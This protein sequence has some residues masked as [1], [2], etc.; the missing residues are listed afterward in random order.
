MRL[1]SGRNVDVVYSFKCKPVISI[2]ISKWFSDKFACSDHDEI[3]RWKRFP[4]RI[5]SLGLVF[6][7]ANENYGDAQNDMCCR[8]LLC[9]T[10][11]YTS[12]FRYTIISRIIFH[13]NNTF[14][15]CNFSFSFVFFCWC[16]LLFCIAKIRCLCIHKNKYNI[17]IQIECRR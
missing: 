9:V 16:S 6:S 1:N 8:F 5:W 3:H 4:H 11:A 17:V 10:K 2:M 13:I 12:L 14:H 7:W 15:Q